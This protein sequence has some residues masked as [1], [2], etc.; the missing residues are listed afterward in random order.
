[1]G[2]RKIY[3]LK[4]PPGYS[5]GL[6]QL[7]ACERREPIKRPLSSRSQR[8]R[9]GDGATLGAPHAN[10]KARASKSFRDR[11]IIVHFWLGAGAKIPA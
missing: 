2:S 7:Q 1:V 11:R 6:P 9:Q 3:R 8:I 5:V 10:V 4:W